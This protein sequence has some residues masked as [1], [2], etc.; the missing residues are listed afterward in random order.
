MAAN[1]AV[2]SA[3]VKWFYGHKKIKMSSCSYVFMAIVR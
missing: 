2:I 1:V 3:A